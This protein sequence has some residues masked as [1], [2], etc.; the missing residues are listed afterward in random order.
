MDLG[1]KQFAKFACCGCS[2]I[3]VVVPQRGVRIVTCIN[4]VVDTVL[5]LVPHDALGFGM[6][7][8]QRIQ[9]GRVSRELITD[10]SHT[11]C[12]DKSKYVAVQSTLW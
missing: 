7:E 3:L 6:C 12:K 9:G 2:P 5:V 8:E 1:Q 4:D 10:L 11:F